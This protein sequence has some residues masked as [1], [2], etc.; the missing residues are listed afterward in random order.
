MLAK[1][2]RF[3]LSA[4]LP[5]LAALAVLIGGA[6]TATA[7]VRPPHPSAAK[8]LERTPPRAPGAAK[9]RHQSVLP[10][11][12]AVTVVGDNATVSPQTLTTWQQQWYPQYGRWYGWL[13]VETYNS[14]GDH[15]LNVY[16]WV[17]SGGQWVWAGITPYTNAS[18]R[19]L[20]HVAGGNQNCPL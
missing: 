15:E 1:A 17:W 6:Q 3:K 5:I 4:V 7:A 20:C 10:R 11:T 2:H 9:H 12:L 16:W 8:Q 13:V 18:H 14:L 19:Y